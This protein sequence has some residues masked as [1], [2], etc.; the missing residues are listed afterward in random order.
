MYE[1]TL[2]SK[3]LF[4][5]GAKRRSSNIAGTQVYVDKQYRLSKA[6]RVE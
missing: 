4:E 2:T 1:I 6:F 3:I 5:I